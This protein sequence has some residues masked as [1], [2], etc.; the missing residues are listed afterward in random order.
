MRYLRG[1]NADTQRPW[2]RLST[3]AGPLNGAMPL[4]VSKSLAN[5]LLVLRA[6]EQRAAEVLPPDLPGDTARLAAMLR[7]P[8]PVWD[9]GEGGT[10]F[11]FLTA[12]L[13]VRGDEGIITGSERMQERP[14]GPLVDALRTL[15]ARIRYSGVPGYPP[16]RLEGFE[17]GPGGE[18]VID[19]RFSSQFLTAILL[20]TPLLTGRW[21]LRTPGGI[22]SL[23]YAAMTLRLLREAGFDWRVSGDRWTLHRTSRHPVPMFWESDWTAASYA[24]AHLALAPA[25]SRLFLPGLRR[26]GW[27][28]DEVLAD[29]MAEFGVETRPQEN[30]VVISRERTCRPERGDRDFTLHP[31]LAQTW[32][33]LCGM[34]GTPGVF[35]GL[36]TLAIKET[37]RM[38]ALQVELAR[39]GLTLYPDGEAWQLSGQPHPAHSPAG[40]WGDHRMAMAMSLL[41]WQGPVT[42]EHPE[43]VAKSFPTYWDGLRGLGFSVEGGGSD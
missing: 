10:T 29:W 19:S 17:E 38:A 30:G 31:D 39:A 34:H 26:S 32:V 42:I 18:V 21:V 37:D 20:I 13:A 3:P 43:V 11:R 27:Q 23:P 15:G 5:R 25:G 4:P 28:G 40:T 6:L 9:A 41:A 16:L 7:H 36:H 1:V 24:Y 22:T 12:L 33:T 35:T 2:I 14:V 8:G